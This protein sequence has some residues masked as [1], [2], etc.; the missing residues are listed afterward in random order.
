MEL[1]AVEQHPASVVQ[2]VLGNERF[3]L[4]RLV[5]GWQPKQDKSKE[6]VDL[7]RSVGRFTFDSLGEMLTHADHERVIEQRES[8]QGGG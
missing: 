2:A 6:L 5:C 7:L 1:I 3:E 4:L 8:L